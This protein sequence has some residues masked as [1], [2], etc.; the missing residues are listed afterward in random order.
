MKRVKNSGNAARRAV[1]YTTREADGRRAASRGGGTARLIAAA[2]ILF[3]ASAGALAA[4]PK[5]ATPADAPPQELG[6]L[7][8]RPR[9][10]GAVTLKISPPLVRVGLTTDGRRVTLSSTGGFHLVD[11]KTGRDLW[12]R[13]HRGDLHIVLERKGGEPTRWFRVQI[14]SLSDMDAAEDLRQR[15]EAETGEVATLALDPDRRA[16]RVRVGQAPTR[17]A[18]AAVEE[19]V[20]AMGFAETWI[21][22]E[23][24]GAGKE[25]HLRLVDEE[26][27]DLL[28]DPKPILAVPAAAGKALA[29][30]GKAYRGAVEILVPGLSRLRAVN[31]VNIEEYL[32][33]VVPQEISPSLYPEIE[34]LKAQAVAARTYAVASRGQFSGEGYDLCDTARCQV[35]KGTEGED[36][37]SDRAVEETAG[38]ILT[39]EGKPI[40]ALY[41][42]TC[43]GHT[44]DAPNVFREERGAYLKGVPCYPDEVVMAAWR[45]ALRGSPP[46]GPITGPSGEP[47][48]EALALLSV[49]GVVDPNAMSAAG[50]AAIAPP[51]EIA[52]ASRRALAVC[53]KTTSAPPMPQSSYPTVADLARYLVAAFGWE[54]R[55]GMF[56]DPRD[57]P[58]ILGGDLLPG[59]AREGRS[60]AAYLVKEG[61]LPPRL[62][63]GDD[64]LAPATRAL[65]YR[66]LHRLI[67]RYEA[68]GLEKAIFRGSRGNFLV[69]VLEEDESKGLAASREVEPSPS[70][71]ISREGAEGPVLVPEATVTP[72]DRIAFHLGEGRADFIRVRANTRG[73]SDDRFTTV[74]QWETRYTRQELQEKIRERS[75]IGDLIDVI[76]GKRG[77]SGRVTEITV[78]GTAGRFTFRGFAIRTLLGI[79]ETLFVVDRQKDA[80]GRVASFIFAGKGW[81]HGVGLCQVGAYG[82]ALRGARFDEILKRYYTGV[83]IEPMQP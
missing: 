49:L 10:G 80:Q 28:I 38:Q 73:A 61:I 12:R 3:V 72:G 69:L 50:M 17:E 63:P 41:T 55:I 8:T 42:A 83:A 43:G 45:R 37:L 39:Y 68:T 18:V 32:K 82:M 81:G 33:G 44:E 14:A 75:S 34:A 29:V 64:L 15:V 52:E 4:P 58:S 62:G 53:G 24:I 25:V 35:Y 1:D 22:E 16:Y 2:L 11:P 9:G 54:E 65:L 47:I 27:N 48:D 76:P 40:N 26:Y 6:P 77:V 67:V 51:D 13:T 59:D 30:D 19:K 57:L 20:R 31:V 79:R 5:A 71:W 36:P 70:A 66:A 60:E 78:V 46:P 21:V 74:Y 56:L 7:A 23:A